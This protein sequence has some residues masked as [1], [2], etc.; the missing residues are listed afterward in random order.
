MEKFITLAFDHETDHELQ[1]DIEVDL[2][3]TNVALIDGLNPQLTVAQTIAVLE[4][5]RVQYGDWE[6][7]RRRPRN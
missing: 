7:P 6:R 5:E 2:T 1:V 4:A 3:P